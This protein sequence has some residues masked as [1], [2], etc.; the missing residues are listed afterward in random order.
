M[1]YLDSDD[2]VVA[3]SY[4]TIVIEYVSNVKTGRKRKY[5]PDFYVELKSGEK[6]LIEVKP[7]R[8]LAQ[9]TVQKKLSAANDW[10]KENQTTLKVI[11]EH[12]LRALGLLK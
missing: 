1:K 12:E 6:Q 4:E 5:Y 8:K 11:T 3:W 10:C 9:K 2:S 7:T